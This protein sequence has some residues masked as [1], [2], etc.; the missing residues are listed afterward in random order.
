MIRGSLERQCGARLCAGLRAARAW[1]SSAARRTAATVIHDGWP[2]TAAAPVWLRATRSGHAR[3][4]RTGRPTAR[5]GRRI[6]SDTIALE[7]LRVY[8]PG[9]HQPQSRRTLTTAT[10]LERHRAAGGSTLPAGQTAA[11]IGVPALAGST[12][13]SA[14][15]YTIKAAGTDIWDAADQFHFVYKPMTGNVDIVARVA[16]I[17]RAHAWSKAGVMVREVADGSL[18]ACERLRVRGQGIR[19]QRRVETGEYSV[20]TLGRQPALRPAG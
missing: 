12:A 2:G 16:S 6:G 1:A 11:D 5:A 4:R 10:H 18:A 3:D 15:T 8:R 19:F 14:G 7:H 17:T 9:G 20:H 13:Y